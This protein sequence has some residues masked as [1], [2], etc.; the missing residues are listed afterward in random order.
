[1]RQTNT[2]RGSANVFRKVFCS[3]S[4][5]NLFARKKITDKV[6]AFC[7]SCSKTFLRYPS[8]KGKFCSYDC[9]N[10]SQKR[11]KSNICK[12]CLKAFEHKPSRLNEFYCS[13]NCFHR[14]GREERKCVT[15]ARVFTTKKASRNIRCSRKCQ[16]VDQ[17]NGTIKLHLNGRTGY[18]SDLGSVHY[19]KSA[20]EADFARLMEFWHIPFEY[21]SKTFETAKGAYTPDFYLPEAKLYVELKGVEN[22]GK[23][24]SKMMRKNLSSHSQL[25]VDIIVLTQKELIQF[26]KNASLWHTI[27]NLEQRNYKKTAHLVKKHENQ[28]ASTNHTARANSID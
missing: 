22:D 23:S 5:K 10:K 27:P 28:A 26:L 7:H 4:C 25:G 21:E 12:H 18:R 1:M 20:L 24:Y 17:S 6:E 8:Q 16:F 3:D 13:E 9:K 19:F 14:A 2:G 15:C 11:R